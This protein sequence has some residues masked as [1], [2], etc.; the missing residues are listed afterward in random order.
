VTTL[1][2]LDRRVTALERDLGNV[3]TKTDIL[4]LRTDLV[5]M[6]REMVGRAKWGPLYDLRLRVFVIVVLAL[7]LVLGFFI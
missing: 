3:A 1:E 6:Q 2:E 7:L 5:G 4:D